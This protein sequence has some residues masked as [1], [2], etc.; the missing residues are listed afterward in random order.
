M[1]VLLKVQKQLQAGALKLKHKLH[2]IFPMNIIILCLSCNFFKC[3]AK[4]SRVSCIDF[5]SGWQVCNLRQCPAHFS[6][7]AQTRSRVRSIEGS[8]DRS[9]LVLL[10]SVGGRDTHFS[11]RRRHSSRLDQGTVRTL[12]VQT[13]LVQISAMPRN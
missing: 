2:N 10:L 11:T 8:T 3:P 7:H 13:L 6:V 1:C 9:S 5:Y 12:L 4:M